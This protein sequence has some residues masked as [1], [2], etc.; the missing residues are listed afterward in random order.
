MAEKIV[1]S[2]FTIFEISQVKESLSYL[3]YG[4]ASTGSAPIKAFNSRR[5][6]VKDSMDLEEK[7]VTLQ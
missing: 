4:G 5:L 3:I 1:L 7:P 2:P 6:M